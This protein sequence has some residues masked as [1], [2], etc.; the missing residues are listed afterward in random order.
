MSQKPWL[1]YTDVVPYDTPSSLDALHGPANG[2]VYAP[3]GI[4]LGP[5]PVCNLDDRVWAVSF[6]SDT[7]RC[8]TTT[9]QETLL[10]KQLLLELWPRMYLPP[11]CRQTWETKFPQLTQLKQ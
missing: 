9:Q 6:Y 2:L 8:G 1:T 4:D 3:A 10:N 7:A 11:R 5:N